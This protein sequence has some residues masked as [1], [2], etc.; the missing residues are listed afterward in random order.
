MWRKGCTT[1]YPDNSGCDSGFAELGQTWSQPLVVKTNANSGNPIVFFGGGYYNVSED[2]E[3]P[4]TVDVVGRAVYAL[5][6]SSGTPIWSAVKTGAIGAGTTFSVT[7]MDFSVAA[8]LLTVDRTLDGKAD[9]LY[10]AD[11]G[12][13]IWR[14]DIDDAAV[15]NWKVWKFASLATRPG[16]DTTRKFLFAPDIVLGAK[17]DTFDAVVIGSGDREHP[18]ATN[19]ANSVVNRVYMVKDPNRGTTGAN[20]NI[21]ESDL[22]DATNDPNVATTDLG[23]FITLATGEKVVNGPLVLAGRMFFGTNHPT[24]PIHP[25]TRISV[26]R[27]DTTSTSSTLRRRATKTATAIIFGTI[28]QRVADFCRRRWRE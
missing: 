9:R 18:L 16:T 17:N 7:G 26:S 23:W 21:T 10:I 12:G 28:L 14:A 25:A 2:L 22:H 15:A 3:P 4:A 5:D 11:V 24:R 27:V 6:A 13:T 20:L 1:A 8:D 19:A